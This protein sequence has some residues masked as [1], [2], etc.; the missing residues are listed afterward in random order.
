M[1]AHEPAEDCCA[2]VRDPEIAEKPE[3]PSKEYADAQNLTLVGDAWTF[4]DLLV[5]RN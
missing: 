4:R 3:C 5:L 2:G 1:L